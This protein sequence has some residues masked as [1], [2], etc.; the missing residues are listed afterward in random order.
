MLVKFLLEK[1]KYEVLE[2]T[3]G[4]DAIEIITRERPDLLLIDLNMPQMNG[5][6]TITRLRRDMALLTMPIIVLTGEESPEVEQ[7]VLRL[8]AD[9]YLVKPFD[10]EVLLSR[11]NAVFSR[12]RVV[13]A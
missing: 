11:V 4:L 7:R 1:Q 2:A 5:Y 12:L 8:G 10:P 13:A 6:D 3:N 9:D